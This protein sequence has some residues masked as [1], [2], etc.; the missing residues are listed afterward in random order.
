MIASNKRIELT[1]LK[2]VVAQ[3][4]ASPKIKAFCIIPTGDTA[5]DE[6]AYWLAVRLNAT[7]FGFWVIGDSPTIKFVDNQFKK[8][9]KWIYDENEIADPNVIKLNARKLFPCN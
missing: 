9:T 3:V 7:R 6:H 4:E 1:A 8:I 2:E 5:A